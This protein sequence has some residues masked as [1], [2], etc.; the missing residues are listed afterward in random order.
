MF[1][2]SGDDVV[3]DAVVVNSSMCEVDESVIT[4]E[5]DAVVKKKDDKLISGSVIIAGNC[6]AKVVSVGS[7]NYANNLVKEASTIKDNSSYLMNSINK[8]LK[9]MSWQ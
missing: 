4:G 8:I 2:N 9:I 5:S 6:Y 1:L 7:D 3:V